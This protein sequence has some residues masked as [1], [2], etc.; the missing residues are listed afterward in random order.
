MP[1][2]CSAGSLA[3]PL[4]A[5]HLMLSAN[6]K[7]L[8]LL[9]PSVALR[10]VKSEAG[11]TTRPTFFPAEHLGVDPKRNEAHAVG[12]H[13][14]LDHGRVEG[15]DDFVN[16]DGRDLLAVCEH[17]RRTALVEKR[18]D[19]GKQDPAKSIGDGSVDVDQ[20][21][22]NDFLGQADDFD[23]QRQAGRAGFGGVGRVVSWEVRRANLPAQE[24]AE[25]W[26]RSAQ[27]RP[28]RGRPARS[29]HARPSWDRWP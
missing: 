7:V 23:L 24:K 6:A 26:A 21:K 9:A 14:V 17:H 22:F 20:V 3:V 5:S 11:S 4:L 28:S 2:F 16:G 19:L 18:A 13:L 12:Q 29:Q 25:A 10:P 1:N 15:D 27:E 8:L